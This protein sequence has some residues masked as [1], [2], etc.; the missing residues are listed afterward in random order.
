MDMNIQQEGTYGHAEPGRIDRDSLLQYLEHRIPAI[1]GRPAAITGIQRKRSEYSSSYDA[2]IITI[3]LNTDEEL[4]IY[5][6]N[7]GIT[8]F[9]KDVLQHRRVGLRMSWIAMI[10]SC[11]FWQA[12]R[13]L[14][15]MG[16][17]DQPM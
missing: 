4:K 7:F 9:P 13:I 15:C 11:R 8:S 5:A 3:Q 17:T 2:D 10:G 6:K 14:W 12:N 16:L 1:I